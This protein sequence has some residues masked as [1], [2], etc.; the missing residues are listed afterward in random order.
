MPHIHFI[1]EGQGPTVVLSHALGCDLSMWDGV[2][3]A[4][5]ERFTVLRYD[6]RGH[7]RSPASGGA[8]TVGDL[9]DDA[10][11][12]IEAECQGPVHFVGLSMGGMTAQAL[13][14]R[15][16]G[17]VRSL[18]IANAAMHY[19]QAARDMWQARVDTVLAQGVPPI[20]EGALQR[21][22]TPAFR[23]DAAR[24]QALVAQLR[25]VLVRSDASAYAAACQAVAAIDL[26]AGNARITCPTLVI[27]GDLDEAT[28]PAMS[29]AIAQS[30]PGAR[31]QHLSAAHLSAVEQPEAFAALLTAF[32]ASC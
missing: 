10:A 17:L 18:A 30:I 27:A 26:A 23:E 14:A 22:F 15:H 7:G 9:A 16:P 28:P 20:A 8:F 11:R 31:L 5:R 21:W 32:W 24:G 2:A 19:P 1:Q 3:A 25:E 6:H 12:L 4:L 29:Q 13:G